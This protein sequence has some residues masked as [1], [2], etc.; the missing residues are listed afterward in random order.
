MKDNDLDKRRNIVKKIKMITLL[1]VG[2]VVTGCSGRKVEEEEDFDAYIDQTSSNTVESSSYGDDEV[3]YE[4]RDKSNTS[5]RI[6]EDQVATE[7]TKEQS[8]NSNGKLEVIKTKNGNFKIEMTEGWQSVAAKE[9]SDSA[10]VSLKNAGNEAYYM[11]VSESKKDFENFNGFK[12][13]VDLSDLGEITNEKKETIE[14][15][16][17]KG[18]RRRFTASKD[19]VKVYYIY[20]LMEGKDHYLQCISW[21]LDSKKNS[22]EADLIKIMNSLAELE[23]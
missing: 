11:V 3:F 16:K 20:D 10:D 13:S 1:L 18:E 9:L 4:P 22:N 12:S 8:N 7:D 23:N 21:T 17:L 19:G 15:N 14:Y 6:D 5:D 2:L